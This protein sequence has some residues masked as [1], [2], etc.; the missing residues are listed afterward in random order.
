M[1]CIVHGVTKSGDTTEQ[2]SLH[3]TS[4]SISPMSCSLFQAALTLDTFHSH[5]P[6][7]TLAGLILISLRAGRGTLTLGGS[8]SLP[9]GS[10]QAF[11]PMAL[12]QLHSTHQCMYL[13]PP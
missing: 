6:P 7:L 5:H 12:T 4:L 2:L 13:Y 11:V 3:F 9:M 1:D 8:V 10:R